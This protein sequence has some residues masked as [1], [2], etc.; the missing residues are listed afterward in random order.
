MWGVD[1]FAA[2]RNAT[3]TLI[4]RG[5]RRIA[6]INGPDRYKYARH[7]YLGYADALRHAGLDG[8]RRAGGERDGN[9]L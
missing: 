2:A 4:R 6:L 8:G 7:R 9:G 3:E 1:D 5:R